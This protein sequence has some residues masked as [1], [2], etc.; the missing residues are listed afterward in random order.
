VLPYNIN[1]IQE[2]SKRRRHLVRIDFS[3]KCAHMRTDV[4]DYIKNG[5]HAL[6]HHRRVR[7]AVTTTSRQKLATAVGGFMNPSSP[8]RAVPNPNIVGLKL[9]LPPLGGVR[10]FFE[11]WLC[12]EM[13]R[14]GHWVVQVCTRRFEWVIFFFALW[15][16]GIFVRD[17]FCGWRNINLIKKKKVSMKFTACSPVKSHSRRLFISGV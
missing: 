14:E 2:K 15:T 17:R 4:V 16:R 13:W 12:E 11:I 6:L 5:L 7:D 9:E 3:H 10:R 8:F 1:N